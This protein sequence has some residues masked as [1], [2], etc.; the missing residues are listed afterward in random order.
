MLNQFKEYYN[1][2]DEDIQFIMDYKI[3]RQMIRI[4]RGI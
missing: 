2:T 1:I 3:N 4:E